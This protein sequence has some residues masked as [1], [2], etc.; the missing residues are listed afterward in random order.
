[1]KKLA[2]Q[3]LAFAQSLWNKEPARIVSVTVAVL[4]F[5]CAKLGIVVPTQSIASAVAFALPLL[6]GGE[7]IRT[8]VTPSSKVIVAAPVPVPTP[9]PKA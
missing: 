2:T 6:L 3:A 9:A 5:L 7:L 4:V 1:M 8:Q